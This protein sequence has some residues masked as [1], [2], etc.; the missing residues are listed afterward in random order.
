MLGWFRALMPK[1]DRFFDLFERHAVTLVDGA[2]A[3]RSLLD[4][5]QDLAL[6]CEAIAAHE[7]KADAITQEALQA[8]RRTFITPFDRSDIQEL[9][10]SLDDAIDQMLKMA[11]AVRLFEVTRFEPEMREMGVVIQEAASVVAEALPKLRSLNENATA[12]NALTERVIQLEDRADDLQEAGLKA[13][14][15]AS[16]QDP[17]AFVVGSELYDHLEKVMDRF[18]DVANQISSIVVEHV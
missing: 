5:T 1:E 13:L 8:V 2:A 18:E 17:M 3:L 6:A 11:K 14:F 4:G 9:V 15:R 7:D 16:R 12:L 10:G